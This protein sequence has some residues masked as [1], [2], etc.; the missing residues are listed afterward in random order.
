MSK[1]DQHPS[2]SVI[3]SIENKKNMRVGHAIVVGYEHFS[4]PHYL[5]EISNRAKTTLENLYFCKDHIAC[6]IK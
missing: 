6:P 3:K 2:S 5:V 1:V 4:S